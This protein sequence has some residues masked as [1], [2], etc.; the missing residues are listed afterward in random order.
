MKIFLAAFVIC[1]IPAYILLAFSVSNAWVI[2]IAIALLLATLVTGFM[3]Q[4]SK[5]EELEKE[6]RQ[7][8]N[9]VQNGV[10]SEKHDENDD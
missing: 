6:V 7:L 5:I 4:A 9:G 3:T 2:I 8:Q 10:Q 1:L